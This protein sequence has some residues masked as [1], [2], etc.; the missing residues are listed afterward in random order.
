[1]YISKPRVQQ[2][3]ALKIMRCLN[4]L[5]V[6]VFHWLKFDGNQNIFLCLYPLPYN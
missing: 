2:K 4:L 1:M 3:N 5:Q 6:W